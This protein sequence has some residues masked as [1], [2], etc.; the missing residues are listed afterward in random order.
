MKHQVSGKFWYE[1]RTIPCY[2]FGL[3]LVS[4]CVEFEATSE[5]KQLLYVFN[6]IHYVN[7]YI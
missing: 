3:D 6:G 7:V 4:S 2:S 1:P 5:V